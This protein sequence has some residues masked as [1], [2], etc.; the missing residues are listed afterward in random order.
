MSDGKRCPD[1]ILA[2]F[3]RD[4]TKPDGRAKAIQWLKG[5][6]PDIAVGDAVWIPDPETGELVRFVKEREMLS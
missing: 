3:D 4:D 2:L 1:D 6:M 5:I